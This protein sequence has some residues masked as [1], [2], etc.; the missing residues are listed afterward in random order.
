MINS[1][2]SVLLSMLATLI[3]IGR[4]LLQKRRVT[5]QRSVWNRSRRIIVQ[6]I[7]LS[8]L[9]T[10]VWLPC[11][12][13][14]VITIFTPVPFLSAL[15]SAYLSYYQYGSSLLCPLVCLLGLPE[16]RNK[17][18]ICKKVRPRI[19]GTTQR[20]LQRLETRHHHQK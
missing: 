14:F 15:N 9:Y 13:C 20:T 16:L 10:V 4:V 6:L 12:I 2:F 5:S 7:S 1:C 17:L 18:R 19:P 11:M 3:I 8:T